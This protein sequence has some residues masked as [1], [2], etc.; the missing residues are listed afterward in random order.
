M[1]PIIAAPAIVFVVYRAWSR[2]SLTPFGLVVAALTAIA[3]AFHP[4]SAPFVFLAVFFFGGTFVTKIKHDVKSRLTVSSSGSAGGEGP[5]THIQ[6]LA[7][8]AVATVLILLHTRQLYRN[9]ESNISCFP[10]GEHVSMIGIVANYA[11]VAADTYSSELGILSSSQ[12]RLITSLTLRK[13]PKGTNGGVTI[14]G[15]LAGALGAFTI[16]VTSLLLPFCPASSTD[17]LAKSGFEG[18]TGWGLR[19]KAFWVVAVT[20]WGTLGSVLD[21]VLGGLLQASV[22]DKRTGKIVEGAGGRKVL[23]HPGEAIATGLEEPSNREVTKLRVVENI[24]NVLTSPP[25]IITG[26]R[27]SSSSSSGASPDVEHESRKIETGHD[28]LDNNAINVLMAASMSLG[29]MALACYVWDVPLS[30][31]LI[32]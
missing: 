15:L 21:S 13:V 30:S 18:G 20:A 29:A 22:V 6:V 31:V 27:R 5:R 7:N 23:V 17:S 26:R 1:K 9:E 10:Y 11:A 19:E 25:P 12:P 4:F 24:A 14:G 28:I 3:H 32:S 2:K 8:S 16:A